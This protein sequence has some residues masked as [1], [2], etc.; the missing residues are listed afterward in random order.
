MPL[1]N[2]KTEWNPAL[3]QQR[4]KDALAEWCRELLRMHDRG[5]PTGEAPWEILRER[6]EIYDRYRSR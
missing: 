6:L 4:Y 5:G 3:Q 2:R 1:S